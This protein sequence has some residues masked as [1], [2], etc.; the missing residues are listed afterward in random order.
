VIFKDDMLSSDASLDILMA[1]D[2]FGF[3]FIWRA[4]KSLLLGDLPFAY[5]LEERLSVIRV[6]EIVDPL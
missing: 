6:N 2:S 5:V 4:A 3:V 1:S